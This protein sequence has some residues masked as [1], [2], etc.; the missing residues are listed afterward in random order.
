QLTGGGIETGTFNVATGDTLQFLNGTYT[1]LAGATFPGTGTVRLDSGVL[2]VNGPVTV[3]NFGMGGG[4][5]G[6]WN[7]LTVIVAMVWTGGTM[8]GTGATAL[9]PASTLNLSGSFDRVLDSRTLSTAGAVNFSGEGRLIAGNG[10]VI[11]NSGTWTL[12]GDEQ[13]L[14][15]FGAVP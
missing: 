4:I 7:I 3:A 12:A 9:G 6:G 2:A 5:L 1:L 15:T 14:Y 13:I 8:N 10:A 11:N